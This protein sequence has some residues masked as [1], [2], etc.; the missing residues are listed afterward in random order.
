MQLTPSSESY[1]LQAKYFCTG[2]Q[3]TIP[4]RWPR[5]HTINMPIFMG[6]D[7]EFESI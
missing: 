4:Y 7:A 1:V 5:Y 6:F 2:D 3:F